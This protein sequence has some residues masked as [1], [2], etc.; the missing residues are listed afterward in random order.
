MGRERDSDTEPGAAPS[1]FGSLIAYFKRDSWNFRQLGDH[2]A[3]EMDVSGENGV[4]RLVAVVDEER[5]IVRFLT[6]M[7]A[8]VPEARRREVMEFLTRAN[9]GLLLGNFE[10][11]L[12]DGEVRFKYSIDAENAEFSHDQYLNLLYTSVA[13]MD[14]YFPGLQRV[15][16]GTADPAAAIAEIEQ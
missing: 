1:L 9:Y 8:K 14:R 13:L 12:S 2:P 3:V 10:I 16:Q 7:V 6:F 4:F 5:S 15:I 11:D